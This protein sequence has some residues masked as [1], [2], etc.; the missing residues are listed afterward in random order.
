MII[1]FSKLWIGWEEKCIFF[2]NLYVPNMTLLS[3]NTH[4]V[5]C[6]TDVACSSKCSSMCI[7]SLTI[8]LINFKHC[9]NWRKKGYVHA[10]AL[11]ILVEEEEAVM[12]CPSTSQTQT[13]KGVCGYTYIPIGKFKY[14]KSKDQKRGLGVYTDTEL[15]MV[16]DMVAD[17]RPQTW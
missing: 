1:R 13:R 2:L 11:S 16:T 3:R 14:L 6:S 5:R 9:S 17:T 10:V 8:H 12:E 15:Q 4:C 7:S